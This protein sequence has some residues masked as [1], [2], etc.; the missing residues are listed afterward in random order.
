MIKREKK[1]AKY[2]RCDKLDDGAAPATPGRKKASTKAT[3]HTDASS[4]KGASEESKPKAKGKKAASDKKQS[5]Y[6][7]IAS[8]H[9][10]HDG[11]KLSKFETNKGTGKKATCPTCK[12]VMYINE[13]A[14]A[15]GCW[16]CRNE[17]NKKVE[18]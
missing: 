12:H 6:V 1:T 15:A 13:H 14:H 8:G 11:T 17:R 10:I 3:K 7:V 5:N 16:T 9:C 2:S 18:S 4:T